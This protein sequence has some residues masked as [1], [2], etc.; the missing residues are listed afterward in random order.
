MVVS[1]GSSVN[2]VTRVKIDGLLGLR[3]W[4]IDR[5]SVCLISFVGVVEHFRFMI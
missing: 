3:V 2:L 5:C 1:V 4:N